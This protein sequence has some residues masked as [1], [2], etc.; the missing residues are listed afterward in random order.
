M[1]SDEVVIEA[2]VDAPPRPLLVELSSAPAFWC[3]W[4]CQR[5]TARPQC[6]SVP[7]GATGAVLLAVALAVH[8]L[9]QTRLGRPRHRRKLGAAQCTA[10]GA[11]PYVLQGLG[12]LPEARLD[13]HHDVILVHVVVD[14]GDLAL[15]EGVIQ[16]VVDLRE[17]DA[18]AR[19]G[20][21]IDIQR[22]VQA[23]VLPIGVESP[24][25]ARA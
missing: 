11:D 12:A 17:I 20:G 7:L 2:P 18:E 14:G 15:A 4:T 21:A 13:L 9:I 3:R 16:R 23:V 6:R 19:R 10:G 22:D 24:A 1:V 5:R 25:P 8:A